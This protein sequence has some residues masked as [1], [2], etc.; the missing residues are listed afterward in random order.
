MAEV[1]IAFLGIVGIIDSTL[2]CIDRIHVLVQTS[3]NVS[4]KILEV[5]AKLFIAKEIATNLRKYLTTKELGETVRESLMIHVRVLNQVVMKCEYYVKRSQNN[6]IGSMWYVGIGRTK[7]CGE[8]QKLDE[9]NGLVGD[10]VSSSMALDVSTLATTIDQHAKSS[11][12]LYALMKIVAKAILVRDRKKIPPD[13]NDLQEII[14]DER[15]IEGYDALNNQLRGFG[16]WRGTEVMIEKINIK[17]IP[18][19][20]QSRQRVD[21]RRLALI[22]KQYRPSHNILE[23]RGIAEPDSGDILLISDGSFKE[24]LKDIIGGF[25]SLMVLDRKKIITGIADGFIFLHSAGILHKDVRRCAF[26]SC[27]I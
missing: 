4:D 12:N 11:E 27:D 5:Q 21:I 22:L 13:D 20:K 14:I 3:R 19:A 15:D 2:N 26:A 17:E 23:F 7:L 24:T 9:W 16:R 25:P 6:V 10:L 1:V 8:I 18:E